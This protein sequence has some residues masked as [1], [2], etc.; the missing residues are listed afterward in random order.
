LE[1][2]LGLPDGSILLS[3]GGLYAARELQ[4]SSDKSQ[5]WHGIISDIGPTDV[6]VPLPTQGLL[7][8]DSGTR[9]GR[10]TIR[11]SGDG[12]K[13]WALEFFNSDR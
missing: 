5:T 12:G 1:A 2:P 8:I 7:A 3:G 6:I 4:V 13:T 10:A 11:H 9:F